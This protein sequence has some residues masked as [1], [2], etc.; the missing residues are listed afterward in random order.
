MVEFLTTDDSS[1][2][3]RRE[4]YYLGGVVFENPENYADGATFP[5]NISY[6]IR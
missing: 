2:L 3:T 6:K 4:Q 5:K 1:G